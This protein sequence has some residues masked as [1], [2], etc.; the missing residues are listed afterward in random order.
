MITNSGPAPASN[1]TREYSRLAF[2]ETAWFEG[3]VQGVV[4]QITIEAVCSNEVKP[5]AFATAA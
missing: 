1:F 2:N 4:V 5:K 3:I